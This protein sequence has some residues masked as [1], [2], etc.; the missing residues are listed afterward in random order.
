MK[1]TTAI[2]EQLNSFLEGFH[3][4]VPHQIISIFNEYELELL[5][6]G[7]PQIDIDD[8][9][10]NTEYV[11]YTAESDQIKWFWE[12][13]RSVDQET[14][15]QLLQFTTGSARVPLGG[16]AALRGVQGIKRFTITLAEFTTDG[17]LP[18]ASTWYV[19][20][21]VRDEVVVRETDTG[22]VAV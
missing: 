17:C 10:R 6:S 13:V 7:L 16:F 11:E 4:I 5:M 1:L 8:W 14:A 21:S 18:T 20:I 2:Q 22:A 19:L 3:S 15:A 12:F 9:E